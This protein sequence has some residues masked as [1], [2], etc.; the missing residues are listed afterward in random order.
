MISCTSLV[1]SLGQPRGH[2]FQLCESAEASSCEDSAG[3]PTQKVL[4]H[5]ITCC[6]MEERMSPK[7]IPLLH[8]A[9]ATNI[10]HHIH[11]LMHLLNKWNLTHNTGMCAEEILVNPVP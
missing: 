2:I 8:G 10:G 3:G 4:E 11:R 7:N 1:T 9:V 6:M 5:T